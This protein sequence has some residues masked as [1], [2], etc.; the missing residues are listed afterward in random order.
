MSI[1]AWGN[2]YRAYLRAHGLGEHEKVGVLAEDVAG[3]IDSERAAWKCS[4][5][6]Q[7]FDA[8]LNER[9]PEPASASACWGGDEEFEF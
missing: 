5:S 7:G 1:T 2:R 8:W 6:D 9:F 4:N 3:W